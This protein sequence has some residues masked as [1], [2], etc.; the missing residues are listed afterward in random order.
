MEK[1]IKQ[2]LALGAEKLLDADYETNKKRIEGLKQLLYSDLADCA[3][4]MK[5]QGKSTE[6]ISNFVCKAFVRIFA[7]I[8]KY[9]DQLEASVK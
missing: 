5:V 7:L 3:E 4:L 6:E 2:L 8:S 1:Q 9:E